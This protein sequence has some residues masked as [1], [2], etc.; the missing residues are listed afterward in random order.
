VQ[1]RTPF[2]IALLAGL[3]LAGCASSTLPQTAAPTLHQGAVATEQQA[4]ALFAAL[5]A[6][7]RDA[8][9]GRVLRRAEEPGRSLPTLSEADFTALIEPQTRAQWAA[10]FG[11]IQGYTGALVR[12]TDPALADATDADLQAIGA[13]FGTLAGQSERVGAVSGVVGAVGGAIVEA[14]TDRD[15]LAVMRRVDPD[16]RALTTAMAD[17]IGRDDADGLRGTVSDLWNRNRLQ[18]WQ[19]SYASVPRGPEG[20]P[21]RTEILNSWLAGVAERDADLADLSRLRSALLALGE[22]HHAAAM[23]DQATT[24]SWVNRIE[25]LVDDIAARTG[26]KE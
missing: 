19:D 22:A 14:S 20:T 6:R 24:R 2:G 18:L 5:N 11:G 26:A 16:F 8:D 15:A 4:D 13:G 17:A 10:L 3:L 21:A 9:A 12:L 25:R 1:S 7:S 23:G